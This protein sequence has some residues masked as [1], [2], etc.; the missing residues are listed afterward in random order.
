MFFLLLYLLHF[1]YSHLRLLSFIIL[2]RTCLLLV[3]IASLPPLLSIPLFFSFLRL[4]IAFPSLHSLLDHGRESMFTVV[5][6]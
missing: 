2:V 3:I 1:F 6:P 4:S 5:R